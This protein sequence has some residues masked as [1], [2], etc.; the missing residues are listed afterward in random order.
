MTLSVI[1]SPIFVSM[2]I[3]KIR[4]VML[5]REKRAFFLDHSLHPSLFEMEVNCAWEKGLVNDISEGLGH[6]DCIFCPLTCDKMDNM[7]NIGR[8]KFGWMLTSGLLRLRTLFGAKSKKGVHEY[9]LWM[10]W[11]GQ[12]GRH[13]AWR[14]YCSFEQK[15]E[16]S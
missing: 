3:I 8:R 2:G 10:Q 4:L 15:R 14:G 1:H 7:A 16:F 6:L 12:N 11:S 5:G 9:Q 13:Q